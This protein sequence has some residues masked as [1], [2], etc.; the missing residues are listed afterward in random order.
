MNLN[1]LQK[2][3]KEWN[4]KTIDG[5]ETTVALNI[6][7]SDFYWIHIPKGYKWDG[8]SI[9][10]CL[11]WFLNPI[12]DGAIGDLIH[13]YLWENKLKEI[14]R[15]GSIYKARKFA[16]AERV[17]WRNSHDPNKKIKTIITNFVI[18]KIGGFFYS[19]QLKIPK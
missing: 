6:Q 9:P 1:Y 14:E 19:K 8:A 18:R 15:H 10:K 13:D 5:Y 7:L 2:P 12:D 4:K 11:E 17:R 3:T 16:D